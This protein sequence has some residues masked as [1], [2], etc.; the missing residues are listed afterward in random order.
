MVFF[1]A[2]NAVLLVAAMNP[3]AQ[4]ESNYNWE[5][6]VRDVK[7]TCAATFPGFNDPGLPTSYAS[8]SWDLQ[9]NKLRRAT[10]DVVRGLSL[11]LTF[12]PRERCEVAMVVKH[13]HTASDALKGEPPHGRAGFH[14]GRNDS[15]SAYPNTLL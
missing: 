6:M 8:C 7:G 4:T 1:C 5:E 9:P 12:F 2:L 15:V 10:L 3:S 13:S 14:N 11:V